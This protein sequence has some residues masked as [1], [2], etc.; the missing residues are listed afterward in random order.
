MKIV[1]ARFEFEPRDL[2][3]GVY[4]DVDRL[5][6]CT[7]WRYYFCLIPMLPFHLV[8]RTEPSDWQKSFE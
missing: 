7:F 3:I 4:W 1:L 6:S 5:R 8:V 2:W